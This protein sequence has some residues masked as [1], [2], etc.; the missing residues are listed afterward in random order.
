MGNRPD[1]SGESRYNLPVGYRVKGSLDAAAL[2]D[3]FN[4]I[5]KRH[6]ELRTSFAVRDGE[7]VQLIHS[8][9]KIEIDA[10][11]LEDLSSEEREARLQALASAESAKSFDLSH[12]PL[13]RVSL[14]R[15]GQA[16]HILI[17]NLHHIV[18]DGMSV[19]VLLD[20]LDAFYR[21]FTGGGGPRLPDLPVQYPDFALWQR[22]TMAD[23]AGAIGGQIAF[24]QKQLGGRLSP[25]EL[26]GDIPRPALQSFRG[27][28]VF[29]DIDSALVQDLRT[30]GAR[31][32]C[33]LFMT[34]L[35]FFWTASPVLGRGRNRCGNTARHENPQRG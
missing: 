8:E 29:F 18:A 31:E 2:E 28:N 21:I 14:F 25:F 11:D 24:W 5:I 4:E 17:V 13:I 15:L 20:E 27:S 30:L 23:D 34:L 10:V 1:D 33:T 35:R 12:L 6:E 32:G 26:P 9:C 16:E 7:P 19:G 22:L 3:S